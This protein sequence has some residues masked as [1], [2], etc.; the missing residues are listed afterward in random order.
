MNSKNAMLSVKAT[1]TELGL[2]LNIYV[3]H[4]PP[5]NDAQAVITFHYNDEVVEKQETGKDDKIQFIVASV[6]TGDDYSIALNGSHIYW[7]VC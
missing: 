6:K 3:H 7:A 2:V 1:L 5:S 4:V